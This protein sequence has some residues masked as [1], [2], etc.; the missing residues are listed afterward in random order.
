M[1]LGA[2][3]ISPKMLVMGVLSSFLHKSIKVCSEEEK[4]EEDV[5]VLRIP[6]LQILQRGD[7]TGR[8]NY[9]NIVIQSRR[10]RCVL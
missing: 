4:E 3:K 5:R 7:A 1:I 2:I 10:R 9:N 8:R 6:Y